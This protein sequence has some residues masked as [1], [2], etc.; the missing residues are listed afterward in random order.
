VTR[1]TA[2]IVAGCL[3]AVLAA[4]AP[5]QAADIVLGSPAYVPMG[6][7]FGT[8]HPMTIFNGGA[9]SGRVDHI[10]WRHWGS[11]TATGRGRA[12]LYAPQGG[13]FAALA[14][15]PMRATG[16]GHCPGDT[17]A[18]YTLLLIRVP[19]WPGGPLGR[20]LKWSGSKTMCDHDDMDPA[21]ATRTPGDCGQTSDDYAPGDLFDITA[22][23]VGCKR[24][25]RVAVRSRRSYRACSQTQCVTR[26]SGFVCHWQRLH[27]GETTLDTPYP[28][29]RVSC[30]KGHAT[31]SFWHVLAVE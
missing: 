28:A 23:R 11:P 18:A 19:P 14:R 24:A 25:R 9:P 1:A 8:A 2:L 22:Y 5:A 6:E 13:Y 12:P 7:G 29:Q 26:R 3:T 21:Y 17:A 27:D 16:V 10:A 30:R 15:V 31:I 4:A 20:W